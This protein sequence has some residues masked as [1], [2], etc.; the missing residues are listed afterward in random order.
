MISHKYDNI[1]TRV[2]LFG[3]IMVINSSERSLELADKK[4]L[5]YKLYFVYNGINWTVTDKFAGRSGIVNGD[6]IYPRNY[7]FYYRTPESVEQDVIN[8]CKFNVSSKK[9]ND[10]SEKYNTNHIGDDEETDNIGYVFQ[11]QLLSNKLYP[12]V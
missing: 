5:S 10:L 9:Y 4:G 11:Q 3:N 1:N 8:Y 2:K 6:I 12:E 7:E